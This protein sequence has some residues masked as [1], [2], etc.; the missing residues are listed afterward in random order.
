M[1]KLTRAQ[2]EKMDAWVQA[3]ARAYD[4]AKWDY[5]FHGGEKAQIVREM[6]KY[7]NEDGGFGNGFESDMLL[8]ASAAIPSAEAIF[9]AYE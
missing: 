3:N 1:K 9:Q 2:W 6:V 7:Q 5:L 8:P 4:R